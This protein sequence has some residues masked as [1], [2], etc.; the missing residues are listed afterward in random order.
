MKKAM[1]MLLPSPS[2]LRYNKKKSDGNVAT[3]AF[4]L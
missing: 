1:T 4:V 3:I 2:L